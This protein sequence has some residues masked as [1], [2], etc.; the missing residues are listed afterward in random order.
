MKDVDRQSEKAVSK[1]VSA[2]KREFG[3]AVFEVAAR[4]S[5]IRGLAQTIRA[6]L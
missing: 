1:L 3:G 2:G 4:K 5:G 6:I